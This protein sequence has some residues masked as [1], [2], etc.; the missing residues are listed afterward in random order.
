MVNSNPS[1]SSAPTQATPVLDTSGL[2]CPLPVLKA[3]KKLR[4]LAPGALLEVRATDPM[5]AID[6]PHFCTQ[7]GHELL[8]QRKEDPPVGQQTRKTIYVYLIKRGS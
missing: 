2:A 5:S 7:A 3:G 8:E 1:N 6:M 4:S